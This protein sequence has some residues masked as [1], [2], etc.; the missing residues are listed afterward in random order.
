M[1]FTIAIWIVTSFIVSM[2]AQ[3]RGRNALLWF[4]VS[5]VFSPVLALPLILILPSKKLGAARDR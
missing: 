2:I 1:G 4:F 5:L 3:R